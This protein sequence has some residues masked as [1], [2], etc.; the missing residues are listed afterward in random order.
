[1]GGEGGEGEGREGREVGERRVGKRR[2]R[3]NVVK[4]SQLSVSCNTVP[5]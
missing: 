2:G 5:K 3:G 4:E 1:M